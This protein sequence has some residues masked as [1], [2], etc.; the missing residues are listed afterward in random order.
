METIILNGFNLSSE[1]YLVTGISNDITTNNS[2]NVLKIPRSDK[3]KIL[4]YELD[5][6]KILITGIVLGSSRQDLL[7]NIDSLKNAIYGENLI[8]TITYGATTR[9]HLV[10]L[11]SISFAED[12]SVDFT[13]YTL[14]LLATE[15]TESTVAAVENF[16]GKTGVF[17]EVIDFDG[18]FYPEPVITITVNSE[19]SLS[20]F[21]L[22][23]SSS[24][25]S[26]TVN[27]AFEANDV[28]IINTKEKK[29]LL[30]AVEIDY[31]GAFP[32]FAAGENTVTI[33][34]TSTAHNLDIEMRYVPRWL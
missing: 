28:L 16:T 31:S 11:Q 32:K 23:S 13:S 4:Y 17:S 7:A 21:V 33:T 14:D 18:S 30:N 34:P 29:V 25:I 15:P 8:L 10:N 12:S 2:L 19:T 1:N 3:S 26:I 20:K 22:S 6:R 27:A 5:S 24:G 9:K